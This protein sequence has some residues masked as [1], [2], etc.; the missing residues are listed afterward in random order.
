[1][2]NHQINEVAKLT[3][4]ETDDGE[5]TV[6]FFVSYAEDDETEDDKY[7]GEWIVDDVGVIWKME[8][9]KYNTL[10]EAVAEAA[11][12]IPGDPLAKELDHRRN[13]T[14]LPLDN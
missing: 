13:I 1:M 6:E 10:H 3:L 11:R 7:W 9:A 12:I 8:T 4:L 5:I 14:P 2:E